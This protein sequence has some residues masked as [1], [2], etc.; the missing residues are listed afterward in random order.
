M[1]FLDNTGVTRLVT[2]LKSRFASLVGGVVAVSQGGTGKATH[3]TNAVL[4]GDGTSA[5]KNVSTADGALYATA[6]NG[7]AQFGTLPVAQGGTG[8]TTAAEARASLAVP[9]AS[10]IAPEESATATANHVLGDYFM[11]GGNLRKATTTIATGEIIDD[12]NSVQTNVDALFGGVWNN[13]LIY[14]GDATGDYNDYKATGFYSVAGGMTTNRPNDSGDFS[15][16]LIVYPN[17]LVGNLTTLALQLY[18]STTAKAF[19]RLYGSVSG[20]TPWRQLATA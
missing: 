11:L 4:T 18:F 20:W 7:A 3:T 9:A 12:S 10:A 5:V 17:A 2:D 13:A 16:M 1:A 19:F 15:G 14:R 8:A 6:A